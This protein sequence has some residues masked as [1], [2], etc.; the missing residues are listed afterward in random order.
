M[1]SVIRYL[2]VLFLWLDKF[3]KLVHLKNRVCKNGL[4]R[5]AL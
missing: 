5:H 2:N 3:C 4:V 1:I